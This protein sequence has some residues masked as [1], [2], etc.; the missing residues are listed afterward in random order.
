M[1]YADVALKGCCIVSIARMT[2]VKKKRSKNAGDKI[3]NEVT[4][5]TKR[6]GHEK[7]YTMFD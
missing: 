5:C 4:K 6:K 3:K 2:L 1:K 7:M